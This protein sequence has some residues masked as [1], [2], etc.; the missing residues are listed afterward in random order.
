MSCVLDEWLMQKLGLAHVDDLAKALADKQKQLLKATL[1]HARQYS[2]FYKQKLQGIDIEN[3]EEFTNIPFTTAKDLQCA[4]RLL[5]VSQSEVARMV[6]LESSGTT[7]LPKRLAFSHEDLAAT[8]DFF[9]MG[10][11]QLIHS[12]QRLLVLWPG[13]MRPHGVSA[14]LREALT[15]KNIEVFSGE[16]KSTMHSLRQELSVHNPHVLVAAPWQ[17]NILVEILEKEPQNRALRGVLASAECLGAELEQRLQQCGLLVLDHYGISEA[18]YGGGV[19]CL[20][21]HGY[22]LRELDLFIEII[23]PITLKPLPHGDAGEVVISTLTRRAMP[24]IRYRTGDVA[25][26]LQGPCTCGSPLTRL[27]KIQGRL[28]Y[29]KEGYS[30][31]HYTKGIFYERTLNATL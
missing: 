15:A 8:V 30:I 19:E 4:E 21:K 11:S 22:H 23:H 24:L 10:M 18:G 31:K 6:T 3:A 9:A 14:L 27:S 5:C 20:K 1:A 7:A 2:V 29:T 16:A 26:I 28:V 17:L 13:A 12:G 25:S